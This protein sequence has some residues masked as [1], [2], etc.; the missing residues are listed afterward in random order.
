MK[1]ARSQ[2]SLNAPFYGLL[3]LPVPAVQ[4]F[5]HASH[6]NEPRPC[7]GIPPRRESWESALSH[8]AYRVRRAQVEK[9]F[10]L[11]P[12][13]EEPPGIRPVARSQ[14]LQ[15]VPKCGFRPSPE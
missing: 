5:K 15:G 4:N 12:P 10:A 2:M 7:R 11:E 6:I 8:F 9:P 13:L 3:V 14:G 1:I